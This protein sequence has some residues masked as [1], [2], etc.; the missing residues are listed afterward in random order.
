MA[1]ITELLEERTRKIA[2]AAPPAP[3]NDALRQRI[4]E[5]AYGIY[6]ERG[7]HHGHDLDD[8]FEAER[9]TLAEIAE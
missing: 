6:Q 8:W 5:W 9:V 2:A 3:S 7:Q 4:A 1:H